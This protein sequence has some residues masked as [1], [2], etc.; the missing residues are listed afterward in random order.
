MSNI[1]KVV[2]GEK[3]LTLNDFYN[4]AV[5]R[6][7]V[8]INEKSV[9][10]IIQSRNTINNIIEKGDIVYGINTGFGSLSNKI[11]S[12][13]DLD[14]LQYNLIVSHAVGCGDPAPHYIVRGMLL[15]RLTCVCKGHSGVR[16]E[17]ANKLVEA[18]NKNY[19]PLVPK[20]GTVGAS[21]D[22][23]PLS[24]LTLGLM[25]EGLAYC[26][27]TNNYISANKVMTDLS[28]EP[29]VLKAK[30]GLALNNGTQLITSYTALAT[31]HAIRLLKI[32]NLVSALTL[33]ALHGTHKAFDERIHMVKPHCGQIHVAEQIRQ[34]ICP[35]GNVSEI[36]QTYN[37]DKVQDAY[38]LRCIPQVQG[39]V[40][41]QIKFVEQIITT[42]MNS[43]NDNPLIFDDEVISGGNFHGMYLGM[44]ADNLALAMSYLCNISERR[45]E[46][47]LN[48]ALNKF[49]PSFLIEDVG[50]NS[51]L[52]ILQ[53]ASAAITAEN[54]QLACPASV[55]NIPTC[56]GTEDHVSMA[57]HAS[58]KAYDS[59]MNTYY[60]LAYELLTAFQAFRFTKERPHEKLSNLLEYLN[61]HLPIIKNDTYMKN[62]FDFILDML[63]DDTLMQSFFC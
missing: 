56:Q 48:P 39:V 11:I 17:V 24:H 49:L 26:F 47:M 12:N 29:L 59:V 41:D 30:E 8:E 35:N 33:E 63:K 7:Q 9:K 32:A 3:D 28:I 58:R 15:L 62:H 40:Y 13:S 44:A 16:I 57:G 52:M 34:Y 45:L 1:T 42:E 23:S 5:N 36:N 50:L 43:A 21:G 55:H 51:G 53:Y 14:L 54:R 38:S 22:L 46:R 27:K 60:V 18:L 4:V 37:K 25:G 10:K 20:L 61:T 31:Y 19:I 6:Y 2:V